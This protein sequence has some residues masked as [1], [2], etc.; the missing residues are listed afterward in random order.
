[1]NYDVIPDSRSRSEF[2]REDPSLQH[3]YLSDCIPTLQKIAMCPLPIF[4]S[5][6]IE[7]HLSE[8]DEV[9]SK[10]SKGSRQSEPC[11]RFSSVEVTLYNCQ[12]H[13]T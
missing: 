11:D 10:I 4:R 8:N 9:F 5:N 7:D 6:P 2:Q 3:C 1:M 12:Q 13:Y